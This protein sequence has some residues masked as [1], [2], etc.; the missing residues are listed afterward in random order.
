MSESLMLPSEYVSW[1][2]PSA[3]AIGQFLD[4]HNGAVNALAAVC[5]A[6]FTIVLA[7]KTAGLNTAARGLRRFAAA[8]SEDMK[9][10]IAAAQ[11]S[12][13][14][15]AAGAERAWM[16]LGDI[17]L[18]GTENG[19]LGNVPFERALIVQIVWRNCGR[20]PAL[21]T[22]QFNQT[23]MIQYGDEMAPV[24]VERWDGAEET[25][26]V[27][28]GATVNSQQ[29]AV[30]GEDCA[31]IVDRRTALVVYCA[32]RYNDVFNSTIERFSRVC[33]R[34]DY[35]GLTR[36]PKTGQSRPSWGIRPFGQQSGAT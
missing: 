11:I 20:S 6:I 25:L 15:L 7:W 34:I 29:I 21:C 3:L 30:G 2:L 5:I 16:A 12:G 31:S 9:Q 8:Q 17:R 27:G 10:S 23:R 19:L 13:A 1:I 14:L 33:V 22:L 32:V 24:F 18:E 26:P 35:T 28:P 4:Q 36:D